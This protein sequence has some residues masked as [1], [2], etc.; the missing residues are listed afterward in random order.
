[1][2]DHI[3]KCPLEMIKC[4]RNPCIVEHLRRDFTRHEKECEYFY[5]N[6]PHEG[7]RELSIIRPSGTKLYIEKHPS[8]NG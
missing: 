4:G 1:M 2:D 3:S 8:K 5:E 6:C 7:C